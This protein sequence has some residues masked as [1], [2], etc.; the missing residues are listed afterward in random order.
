MGHNI[1]NFSSRFTWRKSSYSGSNGG[2][3]LEVA[4]NLCPAWSPCGTQRILAV[5]CWRSRRMSGGNSRSRS[6]RASSIWPEWRECWRP[7]CWTARDDRR[8]PL[9]RRAHRTG[10][11]RG[12]LPALRGSA[13]PERARVP[14]PC[15]PALARPTKR[16]RPPRPPR[17]RR[18]RSGA[19][20]APIGSPFSYSPH[21]SAVVRPATAGRRK[22]SSS[23]TGQAPS[24]CPRGDVCTPAERFATSQADPWEMGASGYILTG[25]VGGPLMR[26]RPAFPLLESAVTPAACRRPSDLAA[27][28]NRT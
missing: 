6:R 13:S 24:I 8:R 7:A 16:N 26:S 27:S 14:P 5:R 17:P 20:T 19:S 23:P 21:G 22:S 3:C 4:D 15:R 2:G 28:T 18:P 1:D 10:S 12:E 9:R 11:V 25:G